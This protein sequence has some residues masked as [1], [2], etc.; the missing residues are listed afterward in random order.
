MHRFSGESILT[1]LVVGEFGIALKFESG[2][3]I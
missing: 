3:Y 1:V 2:S